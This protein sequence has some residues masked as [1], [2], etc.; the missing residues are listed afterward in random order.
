MAKQKTT[1]LSWYIP[2]KQINKETLLMVKEEI[3]KYNRSY[4][5]RLKII[6]ITWP[7][8]LAKNWTSQINEKDWEDI[9]FYVYHRFNEKLNLAVV[10]HY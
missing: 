9:A 2:N 5:Q 10:T 8:N 6:P 4:Q 1:I 7:Q 3:A